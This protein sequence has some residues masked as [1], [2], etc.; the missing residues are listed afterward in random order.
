MPE[1]GEKRP[2]HI[3]ILGTGRCGTK[4]LAD[5]LSQ[6]PGCVVRHE[7]EPV[8]L[9][10]VSDYLTGRLGEDELV[11]LLKETRSPE[12]IGGE[13][14]SGESNQRLSFIVPALQRAFPLARYIWVIRD[15]R[16]VVASTTF[17]GWYDYPY[18]GSRVKGKWRDHRIRG[19]VMGVMTENEWSSMSAFAKNCWYW[20]FTNNLIARQA[21][22]LGLHIFKIRLED[23]FSCSRGMMEAIGLPS[24]VGL[25][26]MHANKAQRRHKFDAEP[27][28]WSCWSKT[29]RGEFE[30]YA[31][32]IMDE[33]YEGWRDTWRRRYDAWAD[34][35]R[36]GRNGYCKAYEVAAG[37][38]RPIRKG[39]KGMRLK[40]GKCSL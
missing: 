13:L 24:N 34:L 8:L 31:G 38:T 25:P 12:Q 39:C 16:D 15:G 21:G 17:R 27:L 3:F 4:T 23:L 5:A 22:R 32:D 35:K 7:I 14:V 30:R 36:I 33:H 26:I 28:N 11:R 29:Q 40:R 20:A 6:I 19:D 18:A 9:A 1:A 37:F 10:E 2:T